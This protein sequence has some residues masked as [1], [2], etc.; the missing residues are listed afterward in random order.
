MALHAGSWRKSSDL[1]RL[2]GD[3]ATQAESLD[4]LCRT[5]A[6]TVRAVRLEIGTRAYRTP[7]LAEALLA[8]VGETSLPTRGRTS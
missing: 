7:A 8:A 6:E 1:F 5:L 4:G 2:P 3:P